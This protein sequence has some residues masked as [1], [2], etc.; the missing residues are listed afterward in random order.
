VPIDVTTLPPLGEAPSEVGAGWWVQRLARELQDDRRQARLK[1]LDDWYRGEPPLPGVARNAREAVQ[2]FY[3][4]C[5]SNFAALLV[6]AVRERQRV[7]G[8]RSAADSDSTGDAEAWALW[9]RMRMPLVSADAL[10]LKARFG[11]AAILVSP[12]SEGDP[13]T[14]VATAEDPRSVAFETDPLRHW[15]ARAGLKMFRDEVAGLDLAYLYRPGRVDVAAREATRRRPGG[16]VKFSADGWEWAPE[17]EPEVPAGLMPLI[18]FTNLDG[19]GEFEP[20]LS[21]LRR[22]NRIVLQELTIATLQA[23]KQRAL[24][25]APNKDDKGNLIDYNDIFTA[26][27]GAIW[28]LPQSAELW[29]SGQ[30]DLSGILSM[31]TE[32]IKKLSAVARTPLPMLIPGSQNQ[33][34]EGA[35]AAREGLVF[36]VEDRNARDQDPLALAV[37][38]AYRWLGDEERAR[39]NSLSVIWAPPQRSSLSER[40]NAMAQAATGGVP[41][42]TRM[43]EYGE[44]DPADVDRMESERDDD[45]L[46]A[47]RLASVKTAAAGPTSSATPAP[48]APAAQPAPVPQDVAAG[49][50]SGAA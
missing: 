16:P 26:D 22:I 5:D 2:D 6:E 19:Q 29:E 40:A 38:A 14:P 49:D 11:S 1:L 18:P 42:R 41:W 45:L 20:H 3:R 30:V 27:P 25:G 15:V 28:L 21:L 23:F 13:E 31:A 37:S 32:S 48:T 47:Q 39:L 43:I 10:R 9:M 36:K 34:A 46:F 24:K 35:A 17:L 12:P 7:R 50:G 8:L 4:E 44:H 33:S